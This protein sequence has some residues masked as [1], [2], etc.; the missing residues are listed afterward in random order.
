[1]KWTDSINLSEILHDDVNLCGAY[2]LEACI[3]AATTGLE[4]DVNPKTYVDKYF[5]GVQPTGTEFLEFLS[6]LGFD[7]EAIHEQVLTSFREI[8]MNKVKAREQAAIFFKLFQTEWHVTNEQLVKHINEDSVY[9]LL[10]LVVTN[11]ASTRARLSAISRHAKDP[12]QAEKALVRGCWDDWKKEPGRYKGKA[13]F[14]RDMREKFQTLES[15][16][17][18]ERWCREWETI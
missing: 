10:E 12:K 13:A 2:S 14:A 5:G 7:S 11:A 9:F 17:V 6:K 1:M 4:Y 15:Q 18:I 8:E 3:I 16:P